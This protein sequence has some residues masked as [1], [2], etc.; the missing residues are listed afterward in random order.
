MSAVGAA[1]YHKSVVKQSMLVT[2]AQRDSKA[3]FNINTMASAGLTA[4]QADDFVLH[5]STRLY[6]QAEDTAGSI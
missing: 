1:V 5:V 6:I 4:Y 3:V 2:Q